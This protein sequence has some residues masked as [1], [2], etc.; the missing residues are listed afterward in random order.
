MS[1]DVPQSPYPFLSGESVFLA[2]LRLADAPLYEAW[3][4]APETRGYL[5]LYAPIPHE[6]EL[7]LLE[8]M[9]RQPA[10]EA[11][12]F[13]IWLKESPPQLIGNIGLFDLDH[14]HQLGTLGIF[15]GPDE[16]RGRGLGRQ[17]I[18]LLLDYA[19]GTLNLRKVLL[20]VY[21]HNLRAQRCYLALGF[22]EVGR[23]KAHRLIGG[24]WQDEVLMELFRS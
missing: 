13:G 22:K 21:G 20:T 16:A 23:Y 9:L 15:I 4:N 12:H 2:P 3:L 19:F 8:R 14:R 18:R 24:V 6:N 17:A 11:I 10:T 5:S 7:S 1:Y